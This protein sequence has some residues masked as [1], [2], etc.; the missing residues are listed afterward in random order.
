MQSELEKQL[1]DPD[2]YSEENKQKLK[3]LLL[4][5]SE[6]DK[7]LGNVEMQWME[8]SEEYESAFALIE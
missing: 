7:N 5:K 2:I 4:E 3:S 1:S 6:T 8:L